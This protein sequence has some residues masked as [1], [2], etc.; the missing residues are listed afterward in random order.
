MKSVLISIKPKYCELIASGKKMV[1][2]RKTLPK[3]DTPFKCY[4]YCTKPSKAHQT[5]CGCMIL[6]N[7]ELYRHPVEGI[8]YG[9]SIE[10]MLCDEDEYDKDNFLNGKIIGE[11]ICDEI[12]PYFPEFYDEDNVF[13]AIYQYADEDK[14]V[15]ITVATNDGVDNGILRDSC[16]TF[17]EIKAYIGCDKEKFYGWHIS[18]LAIYDEPKMLHHFFKPCDDCDKKGTKRCTEELTDCR[19][20]VITRSPQ[21]WCYVEELED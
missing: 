6:N 14:D 16:L 13:Q 5:I 18:N 19:A 9:D 7:D 17:D 1:E 8:K 15:Q 12:T 4:I 2:V 10:L 3:I 11:F 21:S 20:K